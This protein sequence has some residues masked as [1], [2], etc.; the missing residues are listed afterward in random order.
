MTVFTPMSIVAY[1]CPGRDEF[2]EYL[3]EDPSLCLM[4][5]EAVTVTFGRFIEECVKRRSVGAVLR[6]YPLGQLR[7]A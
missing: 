2:G 7:Q 1:M 3:M 4:L 5:C 6:H